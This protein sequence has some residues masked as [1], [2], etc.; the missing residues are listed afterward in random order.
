MTHATWIFA[1]YMGLRNYSLP[2]YTPHMQRTTPEPHGIK[3]RVCL[4]NPGNAICCSHTA[5]A[6]EFPD[7]VKWQIFPCPRRE[8]FREEM[9]H[10]VSPQQEDPKRHWGGKRLRCRKSGCSLMLATQVAVAEPEPAE[11]F[12]IQKQKTVISTAS[13]VQLLYYC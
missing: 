4:S 11:V 10:R 12:Q 1:V 9:S 8:D 3:Q 7:A 5:S 6:K 2:V 13:E